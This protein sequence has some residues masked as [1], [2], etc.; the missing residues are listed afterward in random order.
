VRT[1]GS[2]F[3]PPQSSDRSS[4]QI[5]AVA[6]PP[7]N[8]ESIND[9]VDSEVNVVDDGILKPDREAETQQTASP[10]PIVTDLNSRN[11]EKWKSERKNLGGWF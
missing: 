11:I 9:V 3:P 6:S 2:S 10:L 1:T 8:S 5:T 4:A 7:T